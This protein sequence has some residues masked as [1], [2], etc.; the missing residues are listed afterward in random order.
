MVS[1]GSRT[2]FTMR[3]CRGCAWANDSLRDA[4]VC[5]DR[6]FCFSV[7]PGVG[8]HRRDCCEAGRAGMTSGSTFRRQPL[9]SDKP[10]T[11]RAAL[12]ASRRAADP[13]ADR[14]KQGARN[15][16]RVRVRTSA[17]SM[18][19]VARYRRPS[20]RDATLAFAVVA[21]CPGTLA[22]N[23]EEDPGGPC[24]RTPAFHRRR[25]AYVQRQQA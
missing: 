10:A 17:P 21:A 15:R 22:S 3:L 6:T 25:D 13:L 24:S 4:E 9:L 18:Q 11:P 12:C 14:R 5:L 23:G 16:V 7:K 8:R 19:R 1:N 20:Q 2:M